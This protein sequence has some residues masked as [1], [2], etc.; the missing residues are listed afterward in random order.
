MRFCFFLFEQLLFVKDGWTALHCAAEKG[1]EEAV[2]ILI[3]HGA[4]IHLQTKVLISS[5]LV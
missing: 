3:E 5:F 2:K 4:S 1:F